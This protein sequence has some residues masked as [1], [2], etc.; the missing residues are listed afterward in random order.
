MVGGDEEVFNECMPV[1]EAMGTNINL[2]GGNGAGQTTKLCNQI[3]VSV[4]NLAMA[5]ALMLAA[6]S[7]MDVKKVLDAISGGAAGS[8]QLSN[9]GPRI[10][11]DDFAPGFM[12]K[13]QQKDLKLVLQAANDIKLALPGASIAHQYFNIVERAGGADEGTQALIKAYEMQADK[14]ARSK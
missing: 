11:D 5:E 12:V 2:I 4:N 14:Q 3:A 7:E 9:L 1:F 13:L 8:W 6:A 10:L